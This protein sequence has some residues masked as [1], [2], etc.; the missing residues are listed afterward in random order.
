MGRI[1]RNSIHFSLCLFHFFVLE[2]KQTKTFFTLLFRD[3]FFFPQKRLPKTNKSPKKLRKIEQIQQKNQLKEAFFS[4]KKR[5]QRTQALKKNIN[6]SRDVFFFCF[7]LFFFLTPSSSNQ[8]HLYVKI[9]S[10]KG[11][12]MIRDYIYFVLF[13]N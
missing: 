4:K 9:K 11:N 12:K 6:T 7:S 1:G 10:T 13:L 3:L 8:N 2:L 5:N